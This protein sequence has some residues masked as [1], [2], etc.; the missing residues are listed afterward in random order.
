[1]DRLTK[2][3]GLIIVETTDGFPFGKEIETMDRFQC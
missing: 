2:I 1:M 3:Q